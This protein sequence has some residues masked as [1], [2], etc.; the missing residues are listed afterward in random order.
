MEHVVE[1]V[2]QEDVAI[3]YARAGSHAAHL[4]FDKVATAQ[5]RDAHCL[6][7]AGSDRAIICES[8]IVVVICVPAIDD[9]RARFSAKSKWDKLI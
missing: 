2:E 7:I 9:D 5:K 4:L 6:E 8:A 3:G 1:A